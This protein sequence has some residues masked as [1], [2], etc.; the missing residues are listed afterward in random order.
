LLLQ[1]LSLRYKLLLAGTL[2][3]FKMLPLFV[4]FLE[5][6]LGDGV[7]VDSQKFKFFFSHFRQLF[8]GQEG[9]PVFLDNDGS[10]IFL[11]VDLRG[12]VF[13]FISHLS[14]HQTSNYSLSSSLELLDDPDCSLKVGIQ[15]HSVRNDFYFF[16]DS[17]I[18]LDGLDDQISRTRVCKVPRKRDVEGFG[19]EF[20]IHQDF[21]H[22][23]VVGLRVGGVSAISDDILFDF[24][25]SDDD[26]VKHV[27]HEYAFL[28]VNHL[29]VGVLKFPVDFE[30]AKV[31]SSII[32]KPLIICSFMIDLNDF[33]MYPL[34]VFV[35]LERIVLFLNII[36]QFRNGRLPFLIVIG[37]AHLIFF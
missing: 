28:W 30:V 25:H 21:I 4:S 29:I 26:V 23:D 31:E 12:T 9:S 7:F 34:L 3:Y 20:E 19:S 37:H 5:D 14:K 35:F 22:V 27:L 2:D 32:L 33:S 18:F 13:D 24:A 15:G 16:S 10:L 6:V 8:S 36:K 11:G 17:K 1:P